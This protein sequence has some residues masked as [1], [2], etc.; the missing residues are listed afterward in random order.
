MLLR[1]RT[2]LADM[3]VTDIN[4][5]MIG[6]N[7]QNKQFETKISILMDKAFKSDQLRLYGE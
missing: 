1:C 2:V 4:M 7:Q 3:A 5:Y 6:T